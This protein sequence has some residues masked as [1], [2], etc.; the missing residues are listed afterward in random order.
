M[1]VHGGAH[2]SGAANFYDGAAL[3]LGT[4][5]VVVCINYRLG[6]FAARLVARPAPDCR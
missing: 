2:M 4:D 6:I 3:A 1:F 5:V